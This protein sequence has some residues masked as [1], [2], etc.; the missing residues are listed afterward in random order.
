[1]LFRSAFITSGNA[2]NESSNTK[3]DEDV[4]THSFLKNFEVDFYGFVRNDFTYDSRQNLQGLDGLVEFIP[5]Q[6]NYNAFGADL[7]AIPMT[8]FLAISTRLGIDLWGPTIWGAKSNARIET[9][10]C[11]FSGSG[12]MLRIRQAYLALFWE[13]NQLLAGQT[14]HPMSGDLMPDIFSLSAGAPFNPFS[15]SPMI[16][17]RGGND[18]ILFTGAAIW[19][20]QYASTGPQG[21]SYNYLNYGMV[22][23]LYVGLEYRSKVF[24]IG[25]GGE[26]VYIR[27]CVTA[28]LV[29][30]T[31]KKTTVKVT[32]YLSAINAMLYLSITKDHWAFKAKTFYGQNSSQFLMMSGYGVSKINDNGSREYSP[33]T[34]SSTWATISYTNKWKIAIFGGYMKNLGAI[35]DFVS[36]DDIYV[37]GFKNIDQD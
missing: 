20:F 33:L 32:D 14:W 24:N 17:Y 7:N 4:K 15:R 12:T 30:D 29:Y 18:H 1:M 8:R 34:S 5:L 2:L 37:H 6:P 9:D 16:R 26:Y 21:S 22:P 19:Q 11:G 36:L 27:P 23:E 35:K 31:D 28:E 3:I 25:I 10:F 13:H